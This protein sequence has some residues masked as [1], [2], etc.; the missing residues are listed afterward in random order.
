MFRTPRRIRSSKQVQIYGDSR[1]FDLREYDI[2]VIWSSDGKKCGVVIWGGVRGII[3]LGRG[4]K[5]QA[6]LLSR[7][8]PAISDP[9]WLNGF[10]WEYRL[11]PCCE[12]TTE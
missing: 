5:E 10:T 12:S 11:N 8:T 6:K 3:D 9:Q 4:T 1:Q 2:R 7:A